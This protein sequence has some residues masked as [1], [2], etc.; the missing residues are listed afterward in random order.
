MH[1]LRDA[2]NAFDI[3]INVIICHFS[4]GGTVMWTT[5]RFNFVQVYCLNMCKITDPH[6]NKPTFY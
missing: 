6:L 2:A 5:H 4:G 1:L 3:I